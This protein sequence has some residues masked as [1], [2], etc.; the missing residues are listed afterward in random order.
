MAEIVLFPALEFMRAGDA[1]RAG[2]A[3]RKRCSS[4][5]SGADWMAGLGVECYGRWR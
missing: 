3:G 2:A 5:C 1:S 4:R